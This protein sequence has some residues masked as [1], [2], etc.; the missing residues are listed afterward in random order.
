MLEFCS[1]TK[2]K[3]KFQPNLKFVVCDRRTFKNHGLTSLCRAYSPTRT[4]FSW[5]GP[6]YPQTCRKQARRP[7]SSITNSCN[8][9][10]IRR[11]EKE[12]KSVVFRELCHGPQG[13]RNCLWPLFRLYISGTGFCNIQWRRHFACFSSLNIRCRDIQHFMLQRFKKFSVLY[14]RPNEK[15]FKTITCFWR[16]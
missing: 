1:T 16:R 9:Q 5:T 10:N 12:R 13:S 11:S 15:S 8:P 7:V 3:K 6:K 14:Q 2:D 4:A